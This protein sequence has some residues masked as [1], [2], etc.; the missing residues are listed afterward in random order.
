[1]MSLAHRV[2]GIWIAVGLIASVVGSSA[3]VAQGTATVRGPVRDSSGATPIQSGNVI[4]VGTRIGA[5]TDNDGRYVLQGVPA[6]QQTLRFTRIG[7]VAQTKVVNVPSGGDVTAD[8]NAIRSVVQLEQVVVT[9]TGAQ[10]TAELGHV[11]SAVQTDSLVKTLPVYNISDM[12]TSRVS[13][14]MVDASNGL[15]GQVMKIR[16]RGL[17]SFTLG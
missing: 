11:V 12:L 3:V 13:S 10:R 9:V 5:N 8:F 7:Y 1:M 17:N 6:G 15:T 4:I 16:I 14:A 2:R